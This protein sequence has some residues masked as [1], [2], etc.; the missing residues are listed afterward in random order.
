MSDPIEFFPGYVSPL[1]DKEHARIGRIALLWGQIEHFV[2]ALI[3][4]V[5]GLSVEEL[6]AL[7]VPD[8]PVGS[9][10]LFLKA[11]ANRLKDKACA[12]T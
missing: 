5:S 2:E 7:K 6:K 3:P 11:A 1:T 8:K 9:K 10:V 4:R 12:R